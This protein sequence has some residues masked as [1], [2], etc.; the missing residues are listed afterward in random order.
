MKHLLKLVTTFALGVF[1]VVSCQEKN[2]TASV[3]KPVVTA[4][5]Y[6]VTVNSD[7]GEVVFKFTEPGLNPSWTVKAPDGTKE[8]FYDREITKKYEVAGIYSG[9]L[10][11]FGEGGESDPV[12]FSFNP[13]GEVD[14]TLSQTENILIS[15]PW[16]PYDLIYYG[17]EG[18]TYWEWNTEIPASAADDRLT[19]HK[20]GKFELNLGTNTKIFN[21]M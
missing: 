7:N 16:K 11:A 18:E 21:D 10:V 12:E 13:L 17:G 2:N 1:V 6:S 20:D 19:F 5:M 9:T 14:A 4:E 15:Q 3:E 8:S